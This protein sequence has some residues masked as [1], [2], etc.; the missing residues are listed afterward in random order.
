MW[1][2]NNDGCESKAREL[3]GTDVTQSPL[4]LSLRCFVPSSRCRTSLKEPPPETRLDTCSLSFS[5]FDMCTCLKI[6][7]CQATKQSALRSERHATPLHPGIEPGS[8]A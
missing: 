6:V 1:N 5:S 3:S 7:R 4:L 8:D 2:S